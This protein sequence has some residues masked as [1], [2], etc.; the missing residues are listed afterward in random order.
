MLRKRQHLPVPNFPKPAQLIEQRWFLASEV[1][2]LARIVGEVEQKLPL[3]HFEV[4]PMVAAHRPLVAVAHAPVEGTLA[5]GRLSGQDRQEIMAVELIG[6]RRRDAGRGE[7]GRCQIHCD[8]YLIRHLAG[9]DATRPPADLRHPDPTFLQIKFAADEWP[10]LG[11][12]SPPLSLVKMT[13]V[14]RPVGLGSTAVI[15]RPMP[16]SRIRIISP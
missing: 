6:G 7:T 14:S 11:K 2:A 13:K 10:D 9:H 8:A 16:A 15:S 1:A 4:F 12:R 5:R 3:R